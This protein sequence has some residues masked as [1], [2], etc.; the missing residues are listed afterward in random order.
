MEGHHAASNTTQYPDLSKHYRQLLL[1][2]TL[3]LTLMW[4]YVLKS[5]GKE[6]NQDKTNRQKPHQPSQLQQVGFSEIVKLKV[7]RP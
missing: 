6:P 7:G 1:V 2:I 3:P 4:S 5:Y